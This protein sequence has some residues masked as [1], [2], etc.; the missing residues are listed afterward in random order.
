[1]DRKKKI[2]TQMLKIMRELAAT[3]IPELL[4]FISKVGNDLRSVGGV[5]SAQSSAKTVFDGGAFLLILL[6]L[7]N[8]STRKIPGHH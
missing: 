3:A 5:K 6:L 2:T 4:N 8:S 1:M 7:G